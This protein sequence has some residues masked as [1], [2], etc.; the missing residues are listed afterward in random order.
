[1]GIGIVPIKLYIDVKKTLSHF[2][3]QRDK[4]NAFENLL[5]LMFHGSIRTRN[6]Q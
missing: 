3:D 4:L 1:M 2:W 6:Q 5:I